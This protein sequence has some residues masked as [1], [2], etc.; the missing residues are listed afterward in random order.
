MYVIYRIVCMQNEGLYHNISG[1][2]HQ[3]SKYFYGDELHESDT[4]E[5]SD[6]YGRKTSECAALVGKPERKR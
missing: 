3:E 2:L 6:T 4:R 1:C 5:A